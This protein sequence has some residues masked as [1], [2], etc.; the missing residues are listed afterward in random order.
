MLKKDL[1]RHINDAMHLEETATRLYLQHLSAIATRLDVPDKFIIRAQ[2]LIGYLI[3]GNTSHFIKC[4]KM[5][6]QIKKEK[7]D[8]I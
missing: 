5:M 3:E 1:L 7:K 6:K 8:D 2:K 4:Q